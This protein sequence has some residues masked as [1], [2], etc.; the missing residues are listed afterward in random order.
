MT[1]LAT[2]CDLPDDDREAR[3]AMIRRELIPRVIDREELADGMAFEFVASP[4]MERTL[5][6]L[7]ELE[8]RCCG[9]L[10][11]TVHPAG[12]RLRLTIR[13]LDPA[14]PFFRELTG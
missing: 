6:R 4:E 9:G 8:R 13:G 10:S 1:D 2:I 5:A 12:N 11:W 14:S 3:V 7:V